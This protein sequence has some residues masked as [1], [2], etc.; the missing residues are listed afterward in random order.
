MLCSLTVLSAHLSIFCLMCVAVLPLQVVT[1][2]TGDPL[3]G[4]PVTAGDVEFTIEQQDGEEMVVVAEPK[5]KTVKGAPTPAPAPAPA[6]NPASLWGTIPTPYRHHINTMPCAAGCTS[7]SHYPQTHI[8]THSYAA[9]L[10]PALPLQ[11][12][13][14]CATSLASRTSSASWMRCPRRSP[15]RPPPPRP[16]PRTE[17]S[18]RCCCKAARATASCMQWSGHLP[19]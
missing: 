5:A 18:L 6:P 19:H 8:H 7:L 10:L 15:R 14:W 17:H 11:A 2:T 1:W 16:L 4:S 13:S 12:T 3:S 9:L